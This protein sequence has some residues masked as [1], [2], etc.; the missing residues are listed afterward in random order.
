[1]TVSQGSHFCDSVCASWD[2]SHSASFSILT[3][4]KN[5]HHCL[6]KYLWFI[7]HYFLSVYTHIHIYT[8]HWYC[9][10]LHVFRADHLR[11]DR[12]GVHPLR[13]WFS[14]SGWWP[15]GA[16]PLGMGT[17]GDS[18]SLVAHQ[19]MLPFC[20]SS[21]GYHSFEILWVQFPKEAVIYLVQR[22]LSARQRLDWLVDSGKQF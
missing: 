7:Y 12:V 21:S 9:L 16:L 5:L 19:L 17:Y 10:C 11:L 20:G 4:V 14:L 6:L 13:N 18:P 1:M 2:P 8:T 3:R 15:P 22:N